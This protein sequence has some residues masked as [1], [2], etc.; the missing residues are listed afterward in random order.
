MRTSLA[1]LRVGQSGQIA[2]VDGNGALRQRLLDM[3]ITRGATVR[4][5][6]LAPLGDP[7]EIAIKGYNLAIRRTEARSIYIEH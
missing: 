5:Q 3:G 1:D 2:R 4:V 6:R 7:I